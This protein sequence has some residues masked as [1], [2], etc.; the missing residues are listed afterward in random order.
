MY[1]QIKF[2]LFVPAIFVLL[3]TTGCSKLL[4]VDSPRNHLTTDRVFEDSISAVSAIG[5]I[6]YLLANN[7]N[8]EYNKHMSLYTDEYAYTASGSFQMEFFLGLLSNDNSPNTNIWRVDS[9]K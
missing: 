2:Y 6:Y 1:K 3:A 4:D 5:N 8:S 7:L 9:M